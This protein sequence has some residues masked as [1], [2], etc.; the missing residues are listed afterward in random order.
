M[1]SDY[2]I[3]TEH[4]LVRSRLWGVATDAD[5]FNH[6]RKLARDPQFNSDF[7]QLVDA[8]EVTST[9]GLTGRGIENVARRHLYGPHSRRAIVVAR[10]DTFGVA[11]MF[12]S[13]SEIAGAKEAICLFWN[14]ADALAWLEV[15]PDRES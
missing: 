7:S 3:D 15:P 14:L 1:P 12:E 2:V 6:Q 11:R 10:P 5:L 4:R 9:K 8:R 13:Y